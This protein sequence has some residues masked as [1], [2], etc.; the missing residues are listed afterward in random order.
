LPY[1][2]GGSTGNP[3]GATDFVSLLFYRTAFD[4]GAIDAI[5]SSSALATLL[6]LVIFGGALGATAVL[7]RHERGITT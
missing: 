3:A 6:F 1:A 5:G 7:R 2:F 4:S